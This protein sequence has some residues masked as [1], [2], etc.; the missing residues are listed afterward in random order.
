MAAMMR[1]YA[2][3]RDRERGLQ[4]RRQR[5]VGRLKLFRPNGNTGFPQIDL[6]EA[7]SS[8]P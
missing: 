6:I 1:L 3:M 7:G 5:S 8:T 2:L 4:I